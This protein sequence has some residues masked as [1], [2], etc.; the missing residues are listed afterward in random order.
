MNTR[1]VSN[2]ACINPP[3]IKKMKKF[4]PEPP[5]TGNK[6][7]STLL[8]GVSLLV[9]S[10]NAEVKAETY[11]VHLRSNNSAMIDGFVDTLQST[12]T[13]VSWTNSNTSITYLW[14]PVASQLPIVLHAFDTNGA[15]YDLPSNWD[16]TIGN[17]WAF[18]M[19][20]TCDNVS[21]VAWKQGVPSNFWKKS[22]F[23]WGG[24]RNSLGMNVCYGRRTLE[25]IPGGTDLMAGATFQEIQIAKL[26]TQQPAE[27]DSTF[28]AGITLRGT[29]GTAYRVEYVNDASSNN[30]TS[31]TNIVLPC[32]P[33]FFVDF[34]SINFQRRF[35]RVVGTQGAP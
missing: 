25:Y 16:G 10:L 5:R 35:Y 17:N 2:S 22:S 27:L 9:F 33:Y 28:Y 13:I 29:V 20:P 11:S 8:S 26:T 6:T 7:L 30:W 18:L 19:L 24:L 32:S 1:I 4:S 15:A 31:L 23:G 14:E 34:G 12:F 3:Q 21:G